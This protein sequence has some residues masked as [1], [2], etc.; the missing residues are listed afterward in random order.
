MY[1]PINEAKDAKESGLN[2]MRLADDRGKQNEALGALFRA[3]VFG[4]SGS[5]EKKPA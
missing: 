2:L 3:L 1:N 5:D 4:I